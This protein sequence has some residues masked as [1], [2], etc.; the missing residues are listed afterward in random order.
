[1]GCGYAIRKAFY[2][3]QGPAVANC[4]PF[5]FLQPPRPPLM[6]N[7][8]LRDS[9]LRHDAEEAAGFA[10]NLEARMQR[11]RDSARQPKTAA[12]KLFV[13]DTNV[14]MHDPT[15]LFRFEEH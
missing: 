11:K 7:D 9:S 14:L 5:S 6:P 12:K 3:L 2:Q 15:S 10:S 4:G 8:P 1:M 13:L